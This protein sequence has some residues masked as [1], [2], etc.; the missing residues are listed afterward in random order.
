MR[1]ISSPR[2]FPQGTQDTS[3]L[4]HEMGTTL[5]AKVVRADLRWPW[6]EPSR[7]VYDEAYL[8]RF[9]ARVAAA[10]AEGMQVMVHVYEVPRWASD[11]AFWKHPKPGDVANRYRGFYPIRLDRL[12]DLRAFMRHLSLKLK[13]Q[14]KAYACWNEPNLHSYLYPQRTDADPGFGAHRYARMLTAFFRGVR[15]GDPSAKVVAGETA[16]AGND[17]R[18]ATSPQRFARI[19]KTSGAAAHFDVY[20][21][22]P[23]ATG[24]SKNIA[25][26]AQSPAI[27]P[28]PSGSAT[29]PRCCASFRASRSTLRSSVTRPTTATCSASTSTR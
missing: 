3:A 7:G 5:G 22:H 20:S 17:T 24:G 2:A 6:A 18:L 23:Y 9:A 28:T 8:D 19:L 10:R 1:G 29:S 26:E 4:I 15:A 27:P 11:Q 25:P 16:P 21:H 14:V 13:G 12:V